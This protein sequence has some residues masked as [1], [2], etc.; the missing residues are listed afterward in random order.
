MGLLLLAVAAACS[1][2]NAPCR[3]DPECGS[4]ICYI[5]PD[6]RASVVCY[7]ACRAS[8]TAENTTCPRDR[9][10]ECG[11]LGVPDAGCA[12]LNNDGGVPD[13]G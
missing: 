2:E 12:C 5:V 6:C 11:L 7:G 1:T 3:Q 9:H 4:S 13:A 10:C 8:C